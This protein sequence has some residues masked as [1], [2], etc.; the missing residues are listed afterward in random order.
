MQPLLTIQIP[1]TE[2]RKPETERLMTEF[3][4]QR[5][6]YNLLKE[7]D[8][9]FDG[10]GRNVSIGQKRTDMYQRANGLFV[11]QWDSDD[12]VLEDG[13][14]KIVQA[15]RSNP[16]VDCVT[17]QEHVHI[18]G[19]NYTSNHSIEYSDWEGEG[20]TEFPD[21]FNFHRTP[22]MK[23]VIRT[24][25]AKSVPVPDSRFGEDHAWSK[26]IKPLLK[27]ETHIPEEIYHYIYITNQTF[28][29]RYGH[30]P[31]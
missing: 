19:V 11:V 13:L 23:D 22:Y 17:Y 5:E 21:G 10:R 15:I 30:D 14:L 9:T 2:E 26:L 7:V 8:Y 16:T 4:F 18:N 31:K 25:I 29:E 12:W 27:T 28:E 6:R 3:D 20:N 1:F 24:E